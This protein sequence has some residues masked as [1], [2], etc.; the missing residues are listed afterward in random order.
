LPRAAPLAT[1]LP[2]NG[3]FVLGREEF[4]FSF[5]ALDYPDIRRMS[6]PQ[7][8]SVQCLNISIAASL[9]MYEYVRQ[10]HP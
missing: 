1:Q 2:R 4:G 6:I 3:A 10:W 8:G 7:F 9:V 5:N